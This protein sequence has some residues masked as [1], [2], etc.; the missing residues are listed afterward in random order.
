MKKNIKLLLAYLL[1]ATSVSAYNHTVVEVPSLAMKRQVPVTIITPDGYEP[2]GEGRYDV[3]YLLHGYG[4]NNEAWHT[5]T[6]VS[7]LA[8]LYDLIFVCPHGNNSWYWDSPMN[9][10]LRYETFMTKELVGWIDRNYKT[11]ANR[12]GRAITGLSMGGHGALYLALRHQD[13]FGAAGSTSGGV[14]IRPF[15]SWDL[16]ALLGSKEQYPQNWENYTVTN[17]LHLLPTDGSLALIIDCGT[18][19]FFFKVNCELHDKLLARGVPHDFY[20]RPGMHN[21]SYWAISIN[22]QMLFFNRYFSN[23]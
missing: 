21:W 18:E 5:R 17:L 4:D 20:V 13:M 11:N 10:A 14:D 1:F 19:D 6:E 15:D 2:E 7:T 8:D 9:P 23:N 12:T 22:Y 3:V 16:P